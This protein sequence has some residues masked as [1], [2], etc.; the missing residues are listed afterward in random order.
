MA[1]AEKAATPP[2]APKVGGDLTGPQLQGHPALVTRPRGY[3]A[4]FMLPSAYGHPLNP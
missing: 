3:Q 1:L 2:T 4:H